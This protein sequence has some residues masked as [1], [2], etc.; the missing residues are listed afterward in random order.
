MSLKLYEFTAK[1]CRTGDAI[2]FLGQGLSVDEAWKEGLK[3]TTAPFRPSSD[4][5]KRP[6]HGVAVLLKDG[7]TVNSTLK[8][9][10]GD[11]PC[12]G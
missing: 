9:F 8:D 7:R 6:E 10:E 3:N 12:K 11:V 5:K 2:R 1:N 4:G